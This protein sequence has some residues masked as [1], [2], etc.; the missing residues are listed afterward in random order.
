MIKYAANAFLATDCDEIVLMTEW[1]EFQQ[2][3]YQHLVKLMRSPFSI[4]CRNFLAADSMTAAGF[5]YINI[6]C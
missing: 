2:L 6:G 1:A 3:D 4:D 5:K